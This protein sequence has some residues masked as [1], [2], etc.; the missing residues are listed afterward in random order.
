M[1]LTA[2]FIGQFYRKNGCRFIPDDQGT[3]TFMGF[4]ETKPNGQI[5]GY[6]RCGNTP[7]VVW[8]LPDGSWSSFSLMPATR[9][10]RT[11]NLYVYDRTGPVIVTGRYPDFIA[12][13]TGQPV[14]LH[15]N[16]AMSTRWVDFIGE[17]DEWIRQRRSLQVDAR[18]EVVQRAKLPRRVYEKNGAA[19]NWKLI[20]RQTGN[21]LIIGSTETRRDAEREALREIRSLGFVASKHN[22]R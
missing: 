21:V 5:T 22:A 7:A 8:L 20:D 15:I 18:R 13:D 6:M 10:R 3:A 11:M 14:F 12:S 4:K 1:L 9:Y 17:A 2:P 16:R 19:W